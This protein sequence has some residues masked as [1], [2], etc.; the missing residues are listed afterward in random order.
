M[1]EP[2]HAPVQTDFRSAAGEELRVFVL[3]GV[4]DIY[5][6]TWGQ[7]G[8]H[9]GSLRRIWMCDLGASSPCASKIAAS[10]DIHGLVVPAVDFE[11]IFGSSS[12][13]Q[14]EPAS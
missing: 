5:P 11:R 4:R 1:L 14:L 10:A 13:E 2:I 3:K 9:S 8:Q 6:G 7:V 12:P